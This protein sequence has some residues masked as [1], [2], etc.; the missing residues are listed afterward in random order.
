MSTGL[1]FKSDRFKKNRGGYSRWLSLSCEKCK[2]RLLIYQKD[3]PGI[4]KRLYHDRIIFPT[5]LNRKEKLECKKCK[6]VL[7]IPIIYEKEDRPA[8][9]LFVGTIAKKII[10]GSELPGIKFST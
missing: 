8:Y 5:D 4:L 7:G 10:R 9:R 6:A 2:T 3:G 1:A